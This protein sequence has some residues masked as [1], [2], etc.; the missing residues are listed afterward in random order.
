MYMDVYTLVSKLCYFIY[1]FIFCRA[2]ARPEDTNLV[3][4]KL[5][6]HSSKPMRF[7]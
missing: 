3:K 1:L 5:F 6:I 2:L 4:S 7:I